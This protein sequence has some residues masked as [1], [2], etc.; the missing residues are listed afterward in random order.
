MAT[1][2]GLI[3]ALNVGGTGVLKMSTLKSFLA[4]AGLE[5]PRTLLQSG[6][7]VGDADENAAD[8]E[9]RLQTEARLR[10]GM[11]TEF[12]I[13]SRR[14]WADLIEANP[15]R[16]EAVADPSHL[17]LYV[18]RT[19]MLATG[20]AAVTSAYTG[21]EMLACVA[22]GLFVYYPLGIG[23]SKLGR[24]KGWNRLVSSATGRNW[25]TVLKLAA[26]AAD[27]SN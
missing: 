25:N 22:G 10:L 21:P 27:S 20:V 6:N 9:N 8:L 15:F 1:Y 3:R 17:V 18:S 19:E 26:L 5:H 23:D 24:A 12:V 7:F 13:R 2:I 4:D 11:E 14:E 16:G